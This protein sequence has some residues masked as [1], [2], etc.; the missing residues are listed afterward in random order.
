M[1]RLW[2]GCRPDCAGF[3]PSGGRR[4]PAHAFAAHINWLV[5]LRILSNAIGRHDSSAASRIWMSP[6][7]TR[8]HNRRFGID[9]DGGI[10]LSQRNHLPGL[11]F[12]GAALVIAGFDDCQE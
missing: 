7:L 11:T 8:S 12:L 4:Y 2:W 9:T 10:F 5:G 3:C 6:F 1:M